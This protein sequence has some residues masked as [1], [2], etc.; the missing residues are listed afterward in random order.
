MD[1]ISGLGEAR[2]GGIVSADLDGIHKIKP[3]TSGLGLLK[4]H[5]NVSQQIIIEPILSGIYCAGRL[6]IK[7]SAPQAVGGFGP[8]YGQFRMKLSELS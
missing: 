7:M 1:T 3:I 8:M 2:S 6:A 5:L 4:L